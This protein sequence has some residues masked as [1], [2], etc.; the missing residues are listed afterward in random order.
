[1]ADKAKEILQNIDHSILEATKT[2]PRIYLGMSSI[3]DPCPRKTWL[4]WR[5]AKQDIFSARLLRLFDR[6][7]K[8]EYRF[9]D[10][11]RQ[12]GYEVFETDPVTNKQFEYVTHHGHCKGHSDGI[13]VIDGERYIVEMKTHNNRSFV[14]LKRAASVEVSKYVHYCQMQRYI[15]A[16]GVKKALYM[17]INK[18]NDAIYLEV[19]KRDDNT[20]QRLFE[21][22]IDLLSRTTPPHPICDDG[23]FWLCN[24]CNFKGICFNDEPIDRTCRMCKHAEPAEEGTW[25]CRK[26][27]I[28]NLRLNLQ[29][30]G[31]KKFRSIQNV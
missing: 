4:Q 21:L 12:A 23:N 22:E 17:A 20:I 14:A 25:L 29:L 31:C 16:E 28:S 27:K 7:N 10:W 5:W 6:G 3:G 11:L 18:D 9:V 30:Q 24:F 15:E 2:Y 13:A 1:M 26:R 8:E 19:V